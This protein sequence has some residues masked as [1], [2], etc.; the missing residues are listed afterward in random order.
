MNEKS[1]RFLKNKNKI[2]GCLQKITLTPTNFPLF[3]ESKLNNSVS[4]PYKQKIKILSLI[5]KDFYENTQYQ[6]LPNLCNKQGRYKKTRKH[7]Y[8]NR[9]VLLK[10]LRGGAGKNPTNF[11]EKRV[12]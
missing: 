5:Y 8:L 9:H 11:L 7:M 1:R 2:A 12:W 4:L 6:K 3:K 10:H